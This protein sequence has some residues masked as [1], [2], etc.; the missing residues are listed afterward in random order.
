MF[1]QGRVLDLADFQFAQSALSSRAETE[2]E[3][4]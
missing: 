2:R 1:H 4:I 3:A